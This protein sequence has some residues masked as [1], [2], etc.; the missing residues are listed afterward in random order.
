MWVQSVVRVFSERF[1]KDVVLN[2]AEKPVSWGNQING[3]A[4]AFKVVFGTAWEM[5]GYGCQLSMSPSL[6]TK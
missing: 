3:L 2:R 1:W 4:S 5:R 6:S